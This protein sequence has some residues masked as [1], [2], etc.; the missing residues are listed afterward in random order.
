MA[1]SVFGRE[2]FQPQRL[3]GPG[4]RFGETYSCRT[5]LNYETNKTHHTSCRSPRC[6]L[7]TRRK[8]R[9]KLGPMARPAREWDFSQRR[10]ADRVER[11][12]KREMESSAHWRRPRDANHLG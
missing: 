9:T 5:Q 12:E 2:R 4:Q 10:S 11:N 8:R 1:R 3:G 6:K 7:R